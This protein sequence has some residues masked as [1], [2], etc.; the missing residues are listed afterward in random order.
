MTFIWNYLFYYANFFS[1][2]L[3][4]FTK[5]CTS[6]NI[7]VMHSNH[8]HNH[9]QC[10]NTRRYLWIS[11]FWHFNLI[12]DR[13]LH[14][15][16]FDYKNSYIYM[17]DFSFCVPIAVQIHL[18]MRLRPCVLYLYLGIV[19]PTLLHLVFAIRDPQL[20][21]SALQFGLSSLIV[22]ADK[23]E[24]IDYVLKPGDRWRYSICHI[25]AA[26]ACDAAAFAAAVSQSI[27]I[28]I[29]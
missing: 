17:Q 3:I 16:S 2:F 29:Y 8:N 7:I 25:F 4:I 6:F 12:C 18:P 15:D 19:S 22:L 9:K 27:C 26:S 20:E 21:D 11:A 24:R 13:T 1:F 28:C 10:L 14:R 23:A 5:L